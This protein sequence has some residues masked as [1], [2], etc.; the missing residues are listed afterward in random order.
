[1]PP[2]AILAVASTAGNAL[3]AIGANKAGKT[4]QR[5]FTQGAEQ[6]TG[7]I[8]QGFDEAIK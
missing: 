6:A 3:N 5:G 4:A 2:A 8:N 1:M 7:A